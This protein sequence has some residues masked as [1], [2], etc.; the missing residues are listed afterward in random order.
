MNQNEG[1]SRRSAVKSGL[2]L[3]ATVV[4]FAGASRGASAADNKLAKAVV[5]YTDTGTVRGMDCDD[6]IQF[7]PSAT[8]GSLGTCKVVAGDINPHGHCVAFSPKPKS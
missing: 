4:V 6:C 7:I 5:Q 3:I 2:G 8:A 1:I